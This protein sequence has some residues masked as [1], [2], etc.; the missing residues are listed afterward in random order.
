MMDRRLFT[1]MYRPKPY[2][3]AFHAKRRL[4]DC[5]DSG[6]RSWVDLGALRFYAFACLGLFALSIVVI[7]IWEEQRL[8]P[9]GWWELE[10][11]VS[12]RLSG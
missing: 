11:I 6:I 2:R 10:F 4:A 8:A 9:F 3:Y 12:H 5:V 7:D 1:L